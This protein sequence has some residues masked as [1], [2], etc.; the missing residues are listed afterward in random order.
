MTPAEH[1]A[2]R[3]TRAGLHVRHAEQQGAQVVVVCA[4]FSVTVATVER[5]L[6]VPFSVSFGREDGDVALMFTAKGDA[7]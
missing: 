5:R 7:G 3:C 2:A 1:Y 6:C 4:P